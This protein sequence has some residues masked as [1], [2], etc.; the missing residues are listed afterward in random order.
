[1][2]T[3][4]GGQLKG[5]KINAPKEIRPTQN[6]VREAVFDIIG[7]DLTG[8]KF[9]DLCAGSGAMGIEALSRGAASVIFVEKEPVCVKMIHQN[10]SPF[11]EQ[12]DGIYAVFKDDIHVAIKQF[13]RENARFDIVFLD[14]PYGREM[15]KKA[16]KTLEAYDILQPN[17]MVLIE[18]PKAEIL[19]DTEGRFL[20][21]RQKKYGKSCLSI[22]KIES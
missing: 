7:H 1:M 5:R 6:I 2:L 10:V 15:A 17:C 12:V 22:Y 19:P 3:I 20:R 13:S 8:L 18:H 9:L 14:P 11:A 16:L 4:T 21:F